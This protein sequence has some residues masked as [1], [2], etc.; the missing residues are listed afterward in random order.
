[1]PSNWLKVVVRFL[2]QFCPF[3]RQP[4]G[5]LSLFST[6]DWA[7]ATLLSRPASQLGSALQL[8]R[9]CL[10]VLTRP[11]PVCSPCRFGTAT[12]ERSHLLFR[13]CRCFSPQDYLPSCSFG[14]LLPLDQLGD[15][16]RSCHRGDCMPRSNTPAVLD[17]LSARRPEA[18]C[19]FCHQC[20][21]FA[22]IHN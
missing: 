13:W 16:P 5:Q 18:A 10:P 15:S 12:F 2:L 20:F 14:K 22:S 19:C 1:M 4:H 6:L 9:Q 8:Q 7:G 3:K 17:S 21:C 11:G